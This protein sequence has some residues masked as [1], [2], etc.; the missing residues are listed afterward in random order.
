MHIN[1]LHF[2]HHSFCASCFHHEDTCNILSLGRK[3]VL[4]AS[5]CFWRVDTC[6]ALC[7]YHV[8]QTR[9]CGRCNLVVSRLFFF[10]ALSFRAVIETQWFL[11]RRLGLLSSSLTTKISI[12]HWGFHL[13]IHN[14]SETTAIR[15]SHAPVFPSIL[16]YLPYNDIWGMAL[17]CC[18]R[19]TSHLFDDGS[20]FIRDTF[21]WLLAVT[22]RPLQRSQC[23]QLS[24]SRTTWCE[25]SILLHAD[26]CIGKFLYVIERYHLLT[27]SHYLLMGTGTNFKYI[28]AAF[29]L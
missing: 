15:P 22:V 11:F 25:W 24:R 14:G 16:N 23:S 7:S 27:S 10:F 28:L 29:V 19:H 26:C 9:V 3:R 5:L 17:P 4:S 6:R 1:W 2:H 18:D 21:H 13:F 8:V 20:S 12:K